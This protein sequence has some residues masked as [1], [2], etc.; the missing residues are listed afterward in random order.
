VAL[1]LTRQQYYI[2]IFNRPIQKTGFSVIA[3]AESKNV[4]QNINMIIIIENIMN[5][6]QQVSD[7]L[8]IKNNEVRNIF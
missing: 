3:A 7:R 5:A 8:I 2:I 1:Y 6:D 4:N